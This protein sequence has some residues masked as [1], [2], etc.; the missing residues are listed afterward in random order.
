MTNEEREITTADIARDLDNDGQGEAPTP[1]TEA[2]VTGEERAQRMGASRKDSHVGG[3]ANAPLLESGKVSALR[4][5]WLTIQGT[6]VDEPRDAV[7]H[8]D[9]LVAEVIQELAA[10]FASQRER[11]EQQWDNDRDVDTESLRIALRQYRS[12]MDRLL[13]A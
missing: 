6:F 8:A 10:N 5:R 13:A 9:E 7:E 3:E 2:E 11:L 1:A 12:F 4:E